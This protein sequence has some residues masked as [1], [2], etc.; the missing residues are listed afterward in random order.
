M[1]SILIPTFNNLDY[2]ITCINSIKKNSSFEHQIIVHINEGCDG[3]LEYIRNNNFEYTFSNKNVG[4]PKALNTAAK[5]SKMDYILISHD[6]FYFCPGWDFEL[7]NCVFAFC[8][9]CFKR[10]VWNL[11]GSTPGGGGGKGGGGVSKVIL[12]KFDKRVL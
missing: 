8:S 12:L 7:F 11:G 1:F 6:D 9:W 2:L 5:L 3:T 10:N 4:M